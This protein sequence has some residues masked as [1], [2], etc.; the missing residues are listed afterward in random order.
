MHRLILLMLIAT[1]SLHVYS[2]HSSKEWEVIIFSGGNKYK[3]ILQKVTDSSVVL[4]VK[5]NNIDEIAFRDIDKIKLRPLSSMT[6]Q[7]LLG[8]FVGGISGGVITGT[9][10]SAG[11]SGEPRALAGVVGGVAGGIVFGVAGALLAPVIGRMISTKKIVLHHT[12]EFYLSL[13]Q[14]LLAYCQ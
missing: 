3:G 7:R 4:L 8:F 10:L 11:R 14:K 2:N 5:M 6:G 12:T 1:S 9:I 13:R